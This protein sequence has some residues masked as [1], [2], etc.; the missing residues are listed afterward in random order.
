MRCKRC[1]EDIDPTARFCP[2]CGAPTLDEADIK[3]AGQV[4]IDWL[5]AVLADEGYA[6]ETGVYKDNP[7]CILAKRSPK[8]TLPDL[9]VTLIPGGFVTLQVWYSVNPPDGESRR[10]R[11]F[12]A[13]NNAN[14]RSCLCTYYLTDDMKC[15]I[16]SAPMFLGHATSRGT[17]CM[18]VG[19][20]YNFI[21]PTLQESGL[22]DLFTNA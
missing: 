17:I 19:T 18:F 7:N 22:M 8:T 13:L 14:G 11:V 15:I 5:A 1:R 20:F 9:I 6:I 3:T 10:R 12:D 16:V 4:N 21:V 2:A